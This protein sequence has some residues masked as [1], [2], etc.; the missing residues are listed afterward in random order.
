VRTISEGL[1]QEAGENRRVTVVSPGFARTCFVDT[2]TSPEVRERLRATRDVQ[3]IPLER[4]GRDIA[5]A[6][7][8]RATMTRATSWSGRPPRGDGAAK[9]RD[10]AEV[11]GCA[12][13]SPARRTPFGA[14][15]VSEA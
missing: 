14:P 6:I 3:A 10:W 7:E 8:E 11:A 15:I 4:F 9:G 1:R 12:A 5:L 13:I 2:A